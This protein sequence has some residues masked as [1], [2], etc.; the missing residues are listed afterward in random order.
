[1]LCRVLLYNNLLCFLIVVHLWFYS[2][3]SSIEKLSIMNVQNYYSARRSLVGTDGEGPSTSASQR[4]SFQHDSPQNSS[5]AGV[6][7]T[8]FRQ[9]QRRLV[10]NWYGLCLILTI[11]LVWFVQFC[12]YYWFVQNLSF[13]SNIFRYVSVTCF[14]FYILSIWN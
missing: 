12:L 5:K 1:M 2:Q 8:S 7:I 14:V 9:S 10:S 6:V 11:V 4:T 3:F 13:F